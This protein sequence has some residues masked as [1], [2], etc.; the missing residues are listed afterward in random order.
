MANKIRVHDHIIN[1]HPDDGIESLVSSLQNILDMQKSGEW[2]DIE[3]S[4]GDTE[5]DR[6]WRIYGYRLETDKEQERRLKEEQ[7][8]REHKRKQKLQ[9]EEYERKEYE[10][11]KAKYG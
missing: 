11:L 3:I 8:M 10:R 4:T 1:I 9:R 2:T 6:D 7:K 5:Y